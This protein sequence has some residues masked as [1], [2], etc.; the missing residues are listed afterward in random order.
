MAV[1]D[2]HREED[3]LRPCEVVGHVVGHF[4]KGAVGVGAF[5]FIYN[6]IEVPDEVLLACEWTEDVLRLREV[7]ASYGP[8]DLDLALVLHIRQPLGK[9]LGELHNFFKHAPRWRLL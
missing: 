8:G 6:P 1:S 2:D 4:F 9:D 3:G 5:A 7:Q